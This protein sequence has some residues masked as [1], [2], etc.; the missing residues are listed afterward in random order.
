MTPTLLHLARLLLEAGFCETPLANCLEIDDVAGLIVEA[1]DQPG[2]RELQGE[3]C[4]EVL[5]VL[6]A[7]ESAHTFAADP[8]TTHACGP[9]QVVPVAGLT[10]TCTELRSFEVGLQAG[11]T[12]MSW[13]L[14]RAGGR[15]GLAFRFYN[16]AQHAQAYAWRAMRLWRRLRARERGHSLPALMP[17]QSGS[18]PAPRHLG[19]EHIT[20]SSTGRTASGRV[21][22]E[23]DGSRATSATITAAGAAER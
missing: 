18:G 5:V 10:P 14:R 2:P 4:A 11:L 6:W 9:L 7:I 21:V 22:S 16:G 15:L 3:L 13:K 17:S 8:T 20:P 1:C 23:A 19:A 12:I